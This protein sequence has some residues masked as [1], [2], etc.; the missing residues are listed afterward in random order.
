MASVCPH[1]W[2]SVPK[3]NAA[4]RSKAKTRSED[5]R[6]TLR[7]AAQRSSRSQARSR[8]GGSM[9]DGASALP[10]PRETSHPF[11]HVGRLRHGRTGDRWHLHHRA[12]R[13]GTPRRRPHAAGVAPIGMRLPPGP[14]AW[15]ETVAGTIPKSG[16]RF[17]R[18]NEFVRPVIMPIN[19]KGNETDAAK[20]DQFSSAC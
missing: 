15:L 4:G 7:R 10:T 2:E 6:S 9:R 13:K 5:E 12:R 3:R 1:R 14:T 8:H 11:R 16:R 19:K 18:T 20:L 17:S